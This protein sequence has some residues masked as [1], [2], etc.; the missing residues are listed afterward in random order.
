MD[1]KLYERTLGEGLPFIMLHGNGEDGTYFAH[2]TE[3][4][5]KKY[6]TIALDTRGH[7][8]S[9]RGDGAF[10]IERFADD[11]YDYMTEAHIE[12]AVLLGFSDGANIAM[13]F[14]AKHSDMLAALI[15]NG[16]NTDPKG[17]KRSVQLPIEIGYGIVC[18]FSH[19]FAGARKKREI[20]SLMVNEPHITARELSEINVP[21]LVI[22]GTDDM[23]KEEN[24]RYIANSIK[25][26]DM[27]MIEG[28]HFIADKNH[29]EF[30]S[31]IDEFLDGVL[32]Q[33]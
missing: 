10:T 2:Q 33:K 17:V 20:L 6:K 7:G 9:P 25:D 11:L 16:G 18:F 12:R 22:C 1:I 24:T 32:C 3:H 14:A 19:L 4:F 26:S 29:A 28:D 8:K 15:L 5:S 23:I 31:V 21:T 13:R 27:V 30:N